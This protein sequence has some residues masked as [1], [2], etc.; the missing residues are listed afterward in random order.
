MLLWWPLQS[1]AA[2]PQRHPAALLPGPAGHVCPAASAGLFC[3]SGCM[4]AWSHTYHLGH[5]FS[6]CWPM[7]EIDR[8]GRSRCWLLPFF[9][10]LK[11]IFI[12]FIIIHQVK[13]I[14]M[15]IHQPDNCQVRNQI[16]TKPDDFICVKRFITIRNVICLEFWASVELARSKWKCPPDLF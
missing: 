11:W 14:T 7:P 1:W 5:Q 10:M 16:M 4:W 15:Q 13:G 3:P 2:P 12:V 9:H 6:G 8:K